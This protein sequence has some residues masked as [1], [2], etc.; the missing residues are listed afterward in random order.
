MPAVQGWGSLGLNSMAAAASN[1]VWAVGFNGYL[2]LTEHWDGTSWTQVAS[3]NPESYNYLAGVSAH[4]PN[5]VWAVGLI[6]MNNGVWVPLTLFWNGS[7]WVDVPDAG[8]PTYSG[9]AGVAVLPATGEAW[10]VGTYL[11]ASNTQVTLTQYFGSTP[12]AISPQ[13]RGRAPGAVRQPVAPR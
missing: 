7:T 9:L 12:P 4:A 6:D 10:A 11:N 1:D 8:S 13:R 2:T 3:P 5:A